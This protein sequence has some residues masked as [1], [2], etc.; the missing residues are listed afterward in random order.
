[1][2]TS[3]LL[4]A[5]RKKG[6]MVMW[7]ADDDW[8]HEAVYTLVYSEAELRYSRKRGPV[9]REKAIQLHESGSVPLFQ[10]TRGWLWRFRQSHR[11]NQLSLRTCIFVI[12]LCT[13]TCVQKNCYHDSRIQLFHLVSGHGSFPLRP[14]NRGSTLNELRNE[15]IRKR[16]HTW[17]LTSLSVSKSCPPFPP[18]P[19]STVSK[20]IVALNTKL[21]HLMLVEVLVSTRAIIRFIIIIISYYLYCITIRLRW[22]SVC[23]WLCSEISGIECRMD[24]D[25]LLVYRASSCECNWMDHH[26]RKRQESWEK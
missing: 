19:H 5:T 18:P 7:L 21:I 8:F 20:A 1:M 24:I 6:C 16:V 9:L 10:A 25:H 11:I 26:P 3:A 4:M 14:D 15:G 22:V 17:A 12:S 23:I 2:I 13:C